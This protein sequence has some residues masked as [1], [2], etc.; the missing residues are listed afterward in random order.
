MSVNVDDLL[1]KMLA[2]AQGVLSDKWPEV[3]DYAETELKGVADGIA[4]VEKLHL[5]GSITDEQARL[6]LE[7][8]KNT[9]RT[10][11]LA[12]EGL[13]ILVVEQALNAALNVVKETVNGALHFALL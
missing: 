3:K 6:L 10:V 1:S 9:A 13:G 4:L 7:M 2:A 5:A 11:L 8:K 12:I